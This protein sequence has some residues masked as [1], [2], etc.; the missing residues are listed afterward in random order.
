MDLEQI[1]Q[2]HD[3]DDT[4]NHWFR[5]HAH[6]TWMDASGQNYTKRRRKVEGFYKKE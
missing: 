5:T 6:D 3:M 4:N 1:V 2:I